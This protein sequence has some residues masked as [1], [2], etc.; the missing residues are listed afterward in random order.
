[1]ELISR[2]D[3][4]DRMY[5]E[6]F[7]VDSELQKWD[8]GCWVRYKLFEKILDEMPTVESRPKGKWI[9]NPPDSW[10]CSNCGTHYS[11]R[12]THKKHNYCA[13]CG[14]DMR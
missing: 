14:A 10:I 8:S 4:R 13:V 3:F 2:E 1:M 6:A 9:D 7:E 11:E 12:L 5:H